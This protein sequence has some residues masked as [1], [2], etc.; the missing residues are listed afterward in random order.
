MN[1]SRHWLPVQGLSRTLTRDVTPHDVTM[2][3]SESVLL[4]FGSANLDERAFPDPDVFDIDRKV[5]GPQ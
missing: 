3:R 2:K 1:S 4:L 5:R